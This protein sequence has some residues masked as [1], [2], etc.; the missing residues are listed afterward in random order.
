MIRLLIGGSPC[1][2]W[3]IAKAGHGGRETTTSGLGWELFKNYLIAR[4]KFKPD[5]YLYENNESAAPAIKEQISAEL[6]VPLQ[7]I[8]SALV[9]AQQRKRFYAHNF[10]DVPQPADR[11]ILLKDILETDSAL[12]DRE[13]AYAQKHQAGNV[14]DYLKKHHTQVA[15]EPVHYRNKARTLTA[16]YGGHAGQRNFIEDIKGSGLGCVGVPIRIG[17]IEAE[18]ESHAKAT[19]GMEAN[20]VY[21]VEGKARTLIANGGGGGA[22]TGLYATPIE[23]EFEEANYDF[24]TGAN[25]YVTDRAI[26]QGD[27]RGTKQGKYVYLPTADKS[28]TLTAGQTHNEKVICPMTAGNWRNIYR[29]LNGLITFKN[30]QYPI[31]LPDGYYIIRKLTTRECCRLQTMPD[32]Y[33]TGSGLSDTQIYKCLGNGW[34]AEVIIHLLAFGLNT[35]PR[36][37]PIEVLSMYDGIA[38]GRYCLEQLGFTDV[39]YH[40]YEIYKYALATANNK[41]PDIIQHGNAFKIRK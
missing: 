7:Y 27:E 15:F 9:S 33:F 17:E 22:K 28:N 20:R 5:L 19:C 13:K 21:S 32:D 38:T 41:Y 23:T 29:V 10:G 18:G 1:T 24:I 8:N 30:E 6:G 26:R 25:I 40:A 12:V 14:R 35:I 31:N 37:T 16:S 11:G 4:D 34:T 3:S 2:Y 39:T 36:D